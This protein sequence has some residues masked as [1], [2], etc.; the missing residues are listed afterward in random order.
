[1]TI[2][3]VKSSSFNNVNSD[4]I[5]WYLLHSLSEVEDMILPKEEVGSPNYKASFTEKQKEIS[6]IDRAALKSCAA[7]MAT[8]SKRLKYALRGE[9]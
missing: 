3:K 2:N 1:M 4:S 8:I 9:Y 5:Y 7:D 6:S